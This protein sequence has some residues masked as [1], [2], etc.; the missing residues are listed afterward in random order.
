[1]AVRWN[2]VI[3]QSFNVKAGVRQGSLLS[4]SLFNVFVNVFI[5]KL[6][7]AGFGCI[8]NRTYIGCILYAD[9]IILLSAT[10]TGLQSMLDTC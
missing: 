10:V 1:V 3:S 5:S 4:S 7:N 2:D 8:V 6:R 9:D